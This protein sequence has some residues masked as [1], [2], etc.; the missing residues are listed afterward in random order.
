MMDALVPPV[1]PKGGSQFRQ[2]AVPVV[3]R[4]NM[5]RFAEPELF[6]LGA[7]SRAETE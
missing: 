1:M 7:T 6:D 2:C 3:F 5:Q 4:K